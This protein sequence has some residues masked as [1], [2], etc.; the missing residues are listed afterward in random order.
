MQ[1]G[2]DEKNPTAARF[3]TTRWSVVLSAGDLAEPEAEASL[4]ALRETYWY[5]LY[6]RICFF[7]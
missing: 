4:A 6:A 3:H 2:N 7:L 1:P 5:P